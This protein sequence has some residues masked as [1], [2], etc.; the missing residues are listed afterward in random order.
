MAIGNFT[1][2]S[3]L[4]AT[5][6]GY[7]SNASGDSSTAMGQSTTAGSLLSLAIGRYN[8]GGGDPSNW[9]DTDPLF[10]IGN[11][12]DT[13]NRSNAFTVLK[14]GTVLAPTMNLAEITDSKTLTNKE[15]VDY[16]EPEIVLN[17]ESGY[18]HYGAAFGQATFYKDRGRVYVSGT[19]SGNTLGVIAYLPPGYRPTKTEIFNMNVH[20]N[21]VRID[22]DPT[23]AIRL[24]TTPIFNWFSLSGI[25]FRA[26]N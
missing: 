6:M 1:T 2:A 7:F 26:S 15:Y 25:S 24:V 8:N 9:I 16:V 19:I 18:A 3:G 21:L 5:A 14:N 22:I 11:G 23:G 17:L 4:N 12:I 13:A 20:E 10:E